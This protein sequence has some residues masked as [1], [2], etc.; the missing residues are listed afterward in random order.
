MV[1]IYVSVHD[2]CNN[3]AYALTQDLIFF[4]QAILALAGYGSTYFGCSTQHLNKLK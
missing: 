3:C 1:Y 2:V 4:V